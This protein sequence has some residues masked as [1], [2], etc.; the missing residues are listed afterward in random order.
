MGEGKRREEE[1]RGEER[2]GREGRGGICCCP[3]HTQLSPPMEVAS[4]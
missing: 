4:E 1:G 2:K 3:K